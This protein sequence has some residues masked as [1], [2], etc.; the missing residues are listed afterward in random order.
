MPF[1]GQHNNAAAVTANVFQI[2]ALSSPSHEPLLDAPIAVGGDAKRSPQPPVRQRAVAFQSPSE[3]GAGKLIK[4]PNPQ[5]VLCGRG[6][7]V[8]FHPGNAT[9][10]DL[11]ERSQAEYLCAKRSDKPQIATFIL[12][13]IK[14]L[15]GRFLKKSRDRTKKGRSHV[16]WEELDDYKAYERVC[17]G[18]R[19]GA[20]E[21]RRRMMETAKLSD[22]MMGDDHHDGGGSVMNDNHDGGAGGRMVVRDK[23]NAGNYDGGGTNQGWGTNL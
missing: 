3:M 13:E 21:V 1:Q 12:D 16:M 11:I 17:H 23:E 22:A 5:D 2:P 6:A 19:E 20:P 14:S 4:N 9:F 7:P 15:G 18:L 10:R 8:T